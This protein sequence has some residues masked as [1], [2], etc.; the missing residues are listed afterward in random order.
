MR[1]VS[2]IG[3]SLPVFVL[4]LLCLLV[5]YVHWGIAPGTGQQ[6]VI[7]QYK[8][9]KWNPPIIQGAFHL[10]EPD[11]MRKQFVNCQD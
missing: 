7:F 4:A 5:F 10:V 6:D 9:A 3:Q 8:D 11:G 1:V 2:L